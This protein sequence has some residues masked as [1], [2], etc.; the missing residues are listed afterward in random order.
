[1]SDRQDKRRLSRVAELIG[2]E[3]VAMDEGSEIRWR[4]RIRC[5]GTNTDGWVVRLGNL[6]KGRP[7]LELWLDRYARRGE[8]CFWFGLYSPQH[9][10]LRRL[11]KKL[12]DDFQ[13][14]HELSDDDYEKVGRSTW[15]LGKEFTKREFNQPVFE[16]YYNQIAFYGLFDRTSDRTVKSDRLV[17]RRAVAFF[18]DVLH[19]LPNAPA[20]REDS[21]VYQGVENRQVVREHLTRE[22][23]RLLAESRKIRDKY[24][25]QTCR[26]NF[27]EVYGELGAEVAEAHHIIPLSRLK[28]KVTTTI[29]DLI[30]VC[31][32]CHRMLHKMDG[33][34]GDVPRL[35]KLISKHKRR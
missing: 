27:E 7:Y 12:P 35:R 34:R 8:R 5:E 29:D 6:G 28:G 23:N 1:M 14:E 33:K 11:V 3:L 19:H 25:C 4:D 15:L 10:K 16:F 2:A 17:A 26:M 13:F 31:S 20:R 9:Q 21:G 32:N 24:R 22:R 18:A 30:T